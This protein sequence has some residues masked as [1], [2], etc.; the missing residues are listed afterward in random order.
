MVSSEV[1]DGLSVRSAALWSG[2]VSTFELRADELALLE[3]ACRTLDDAARI[4]AA[5]AETDVVSVGSTGQP[6]AHPLLRELR[7]TRL[8]ASKLLAV[9]DLPEDG[10]GS[11]WDGLSASGRARKA[12]L[13]RWSA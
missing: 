8:T 13:A 9:L 2:T 7:D 3:L 4:A 5:L 6:V 11:V 10:A 1:P 12:A